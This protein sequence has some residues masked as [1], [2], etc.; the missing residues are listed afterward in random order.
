VSVT[1]IYTCDRCGTEQNSSQN[2]WVIGIAA[3]HSVYKSL[4]EREFIR[5]MS[6]Q[7]C[8]PCLEHF[9][10]HVISRPDPKSEAKEEPTL[11]QRIVDLIADIARREV[12]Q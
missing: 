6:M 7:V 1:T 11:E 12:Q 8:R 4:T 2:F 10:V 5:D 3:H 9:G